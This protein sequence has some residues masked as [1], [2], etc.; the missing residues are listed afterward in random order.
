MK[1]CIPS[2]TAFDTFRTTFHAIMMKK[3]SET[4]VEAAAEIK[5]VS[6]GSELIFKLFS[7]DDY[8]VFQLKKD[9]ENIDN[10]HNTYTRNNLGF[11]IITAFLLH[12][13]PF[14]SC[15]E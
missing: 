8:T 13:I 10:A 11:D 9:S 2:F 7:D 14:Y 12:F 5:R 3:R 6:L 4:N 1:D 15:L